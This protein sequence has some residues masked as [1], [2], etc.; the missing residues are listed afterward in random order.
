MRIIYIILVASIIFVSCDT[1]EKRNAESASEGVVV[2][3]CCNSPGWIR[4][5]NSFP[6]RIKKIWITGEGEWTKWLYKFEPGQMIPEFIGELDGFYVLSTEGGAIGWIRPTA[7]GC[8]ND[9]GQN[10]T[11]AWPIRHSGRF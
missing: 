8:S 2:H 1:D 9:I 5:T 11:K 4:N 6:V 10:Q 7:N 3:G